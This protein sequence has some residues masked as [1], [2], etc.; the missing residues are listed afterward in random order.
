MI[1]RQTEARI[2]STTDALAQKSALLDAL[3][4]ENNLLKSE[5]SIQK[6]C[7]VEQ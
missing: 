4:S 5:K 7:H 2:S 3:I 6:V 1:L